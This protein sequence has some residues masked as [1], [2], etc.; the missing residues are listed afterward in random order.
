MKKLKY[1]FTYIKSELTKGIE[2]INS[3]NMNSDKKGNVYFLIVLIIV[4]GIIA[5]YFGM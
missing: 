4:L 3:V 2:Y 1:M 5:F